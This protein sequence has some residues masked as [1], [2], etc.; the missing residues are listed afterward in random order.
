MLRPWY[1]TD[2][3]DEVNSPALL[4]YPD[5]VQANLDR[6][7]EMAGSSDRLRPHVKTHKMPAI[8]QLNIAAGITRFKAATIAE[9]EMTAEAGAQDVLL[10]V[11]P[12]GPNVQRLVKLIKRYPGCLFSCL[13]DEPA[14]LVQLEN[15]FQGA[16]VCGSVWLD[17]NV[18]MN[19]TGIAPS[20]AASDLIRSLLSSEHVGF[21]GIH[22]YDGHLHDTDAERL[23]QQFDGVMKPFWA[24]L[25]ESQ[26]ASGTRPRLVAGGTPTASFWQAEAG[27]RQLEIETGAGTTVLWD[28]G[29]PTFS[30][31]MPFEPAAVVV[32]RVISRPTESHVCLDLGHKSIASEMP[33]PR[34]KWLNWEEEHEV[35]GHNEEHLV[36]QTKERCSLRCGDV[37]YGVP[38]HIC[39]TVALHQHAECVRDHRVSEQWQVV[40]RDRKLTI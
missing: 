18:G 30:P 15:A 4:V 39:P 37:L 36:L 34:V 27:A 24:W 21:A 1:E 19:R 14:V 9:A 20:A 29:Q 28:A 3:L 12:V 40:A 22:V 6:M 17:I 23:K 16:G 38:V 11:Q 2:N 35:V 13:V 5:R 32:T 8:T 33:L 7:I 26:R 31:A 10:A 25:A